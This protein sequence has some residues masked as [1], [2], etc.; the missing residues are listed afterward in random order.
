MKPP[1]SPATDVLLSVLA[2][3][4]FLFHVLL[5]EGDDGSPTMIPATAHPSMT[6][7][8]STMPV[9]LSVSKTNSS[10]LVEAVPPLLMT[11]IPLSRDGYY[12]PMVKTLLQHTAASLQYLQVYKSTVCPVYV[13]MSYRQQ[14]VPDM[15]KSYVAPVIMFPSPGISISSSIMSASVQVCMCDSDLQKTAAAAAAA[16]SYSACSSGGAT[17]AD[18]AGAP[19]NAN[20]GHGHV[21]NCC[22]NLH[23][24]C[25]AYM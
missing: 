15:C 17:T 5:P 21:H 1:D 8:S 13:N 23:G 25:C 7:I 22:T 19:I 20:Q 4:V 14:Q 3:V 2:S 6:G 16:D 24:T 18:G 11:C 10:P 9:A 12:K